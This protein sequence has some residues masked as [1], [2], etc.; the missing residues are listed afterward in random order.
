MFEKLPSLLAYQPQF[1][2]GGPIGLHRPFLYDLV[3]NAKPKLVVT[4]GFADGEAFFTLCQAA[5]EQGIAMRCLAL[6]RDVGQ[7]S[8][9]RAW[10]EGMTHASEFYP[11]IAELR[12]VSSAELA[13][14]LGDDSVD[15]LLVDDCDSGSVVARD[16][17]SWKTKLA[18]GA[19]VLVHGIALEREDAPRN[20]WRNFSQQQ[21]SVELS[22]GI[23][24][25]ITRLGPAADLFAEWFGFPIAEVQTLHRFA[26]Q[27]AHAEALAREA[28]RK[29]AAFEVQNAWLHSVLS[30]DSDVRE[31]IQS[32]SAS[33]SDLKQKVEPLQRDRAKAQLVMDA[34]A[35]KLVTWAAQIEALCSERDKLLAQVKKQK[36]I[37]SAA[38][39]AC[40]KHGNCFRVSLTPEPKTHRGVRERIA[41]E[42][43]RWPRKVRSLI[44]PPPIE[45]VAEKMVAAEPV[46]K[47]RYELWIEANEPPA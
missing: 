29:T 19:V 21:A 40:R 34:Q 20:A 38:K 5:Q 47:D 16:L 4:V 3:A 37:I 11:Q 36:A 27:R 44:A 32:L 41:R 39:Q 12:T 15:I 17:S 28:A 13:D 10:R 43:N 26:W 2:R 24:L 6:P 45:K 42:V 14:S 46:V 1:Y 33:T 8:E 25:G 35:E 9:D 23:G 30:K 31:F 22:G 7:A 18:P